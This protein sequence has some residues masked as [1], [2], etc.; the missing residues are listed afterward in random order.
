MR[1]II[2]SA[3][4]AA[5]LATSAGAVTTVSGSSS[6]GSALGGGSSTTVITPTSG[7]SYTEF[8]LVSDA[9]NAVTFSFDAASQLSVT[10]I[11]VSGTG[12]LAD[13]AKIT[14]TLSTLAGTYTFALTDVPFSTADSGTGGFAGFDMAAGQIESITFSTTGT[15]SDNVTLGATVLTAPIPVPAALPL[16]LGGLGG[17]V[18]LGRRKA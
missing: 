5:A 7:A 8:Y 16:M 15:L 17:L 18:A 6:T 1:N 13:L 11:S 2:L 9:A 10:G 12:K 3:V 14:Y 4:A